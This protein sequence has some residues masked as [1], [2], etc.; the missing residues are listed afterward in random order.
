MSDAINK[1]ILHLQS[2]IKLLQE[3]KTEQKR[4]LKDFNPMS[5]KTWLK[6]IKLIDDPHFC[7][8]LIIQLEARKQQLKPDF[9][10]E[11][12]TR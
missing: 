6:M 2:A 7:E 3:R 8:T 4:M 12:V 10:S 5:K 11:T 1:S 9:T